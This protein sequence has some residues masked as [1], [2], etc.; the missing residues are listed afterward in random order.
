MSDSSTC[1]QVHAQEDEEEEEE[2]EEGREKGIIAWRD[3][4]PHRTM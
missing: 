1:L 2:E 4:S 3:L